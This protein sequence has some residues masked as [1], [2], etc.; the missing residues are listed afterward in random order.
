MNKVS[1]KLA[2]ELYLY[3]VMRLRFLDV[4]KKC[5]A[6]L[7]YCQYHATQVH[8]KRGRG[9]YLL[10]LETWLAVCPSCHQRIELNPAWAKL[11][12]LSL[13][14]LTTDKDIVDMYGNVIIETQHDKVSET[15][16]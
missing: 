10:D 6:S 13:D 5:Q 9:L 7:R 11:I 14:R 2:E 15:R 4:F 1:D 3:G 12:G 16:L 8:H